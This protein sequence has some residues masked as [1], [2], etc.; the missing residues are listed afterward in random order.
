[1]PVGVPEPERH[2]EIGGIPIRVTGWAFFARERPGVTQVIT[3]NAELL[4]LAQHQARF[5]RIAEENHVSIDGQ[6]P[7]WI[8]RLLNS[9]PDIEK[10]S[11]SDLIHRAAR[12]AA[13]DEATLMLLGG[14]QME[15]LLA[16]EALRAA[17]SASVV[18]YAPAHTAYPFSPVELERIKTEIR[19]C[20][21]TIILVALGAPKQEYLIDDL[22]EFLG[23]VGVRL[24]VGVGGALRM[25]AGLE[26]RAP[27]WV[28]SAGL[29]GVWRLALDPGR[30]RRWPAALAG[31]P[32]WFR[33]SAPS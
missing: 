24:A 26:R 2:P 22:R 32:G 29:E 33:R 19:E 13:N 8:A 30:I 27:R 6:A 25:V 31:V 21:P 15:N 14:T 9:R 3:L 5:R 18:G 1:M 11:G 28:Q 7:L 4:A 20:R 23:E 16:A 17:T 10:V 12:W